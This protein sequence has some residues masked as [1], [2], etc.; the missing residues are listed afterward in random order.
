MSDKPCIS[1]TP[2]GRAFPLP[3]SLGEAVEIIA[4][5]RAELAAVAVAVGRS[6]T[7]GYD[8]DWYELHKLC[9]R[10]ETTDTTPRDLAMMI[11]KLSAR[12]GRR[13]NAESD[14]ALVATALDL[15]KRKGLEGSITREEGYCERLT[16]GE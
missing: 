8:V 13:S 16:N 9:Q 5:L 15:L 7:D 4:H 11:R 1:G 14:K 10:S 3:A 6:K 12:L 2:Q